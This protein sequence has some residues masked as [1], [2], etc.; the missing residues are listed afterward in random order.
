MKNTPI[1]DHRIR[2]CQPGLVQT[3]HKPVSLY[4][5]IE[6]SNTEE[7][8]PGTVTI[9]RLIP[10]PF[11]LTFTLYIYI[12]NSLKREIFLVDR[13]MEGNPEEENK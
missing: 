9:F 10:N 2:S 6:N 13:V 3:H 1:K 7:N 8:S 4:Y 5:Q 12:K 11:S